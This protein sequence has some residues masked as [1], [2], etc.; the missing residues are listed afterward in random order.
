MVDWTNLRHA[1][2]AAGDVPALLDS[3]TPDPADEVWGELWSR[4]CHQGSVY[5]ASFAAL[6]AL[7]DAAARWQPKQRVQPLALAGCILASEDCRDEGGRNLVEVFFQENRPVVRRFQELCQESLAQPG[8]PEGDFIYLL[9]AARTFDRDEFWG[10]KLDQ[11]AGGEFSGICPRCG[12]DL[13]L[14]IG[15][16]GY[17][18]TTED[19]VSRGNN[20]GKLQPRTDVKLAPIEQARGALPPTG[21]WMYD[22]CIAADQAALAECIKYVFGTSTCTTCSEN[23]ALQEAIAKA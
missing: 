2:G 23:F 16:Y 11:F 8:L 13:Y 12:A 22:R 7:A 9:Q 18:A 17:F 5:S 14:V 3:L 15:K 1:Y 4:I 19:W 20:S 10:R 6:P 21:Q